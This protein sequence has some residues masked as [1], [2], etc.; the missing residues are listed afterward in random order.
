MDYNQRIE[1]ALTIIWEE[2]EKKISNKDAIAK[3][4]L[5]AVNED[6]S[7]SLLSEGFVLIEKDIIKFSNKGESKARDIIRRQRLAERLLMDVLELGRREVDSSACAFEHILSKEVEESICTLLGHPKECPHGL[8]IPAGACCEKAKGLIESIVI[9]LTKLKVAETGK[10]VY[11]LTRNHPQLHRLMSFGIV[12]GA[13]IKLHQTQP[14]VIIQV[15]ET[16][17]A[18]EEEIAKEIYIKKIS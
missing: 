7:E 14:S 15:E 17:V 16:Q 8:S 18:L 1:E 11:V 12:P 5:E 10:I 13:R 9:P 3:R 2:R 6:V 4:F